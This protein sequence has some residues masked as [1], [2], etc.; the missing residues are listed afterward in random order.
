V[1]W[2]FRA[3]A[4]YGEMLSARTEGALVEELLLPVGGSWRFG[5]ACGDDGVGLFIRNIFGI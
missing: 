4:E 5:H 3:R 2:F 1:G